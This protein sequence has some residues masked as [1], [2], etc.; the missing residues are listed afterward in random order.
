[1]PWAEAD[2]SGLPFTHTAPGPCLQ[3]L[4]LVTVY[5]V[6][7]GGAGRAQPTSPG[8]AP[9]P[10]RQSMAFTMKSTMQQSMAGVRG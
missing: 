2:T 1:M 4:E 10:G 5:R 8:R 9:Q 6:G 7:Q 3:A